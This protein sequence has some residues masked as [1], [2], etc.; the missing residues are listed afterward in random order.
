[1]KISIIA[2]EVSKFGELYDLSIFDLSSSIVKRLLSSTELEE[3]DIEAVFVANMAAGSFS[4]Q[5]HLNAIVSNCFSHHP[6]AFR[7]EAACASGGLA[8][9]AAQ[10][11]LLSGQ[12]QTVM[13]LGVE[14]MT[15]VDA[16]LAN[17]ILCSAAHSESE[18]G[19]TFAGL[20]A[21]VAAAYLKEYQYSREV[22]SA[23]AIKNHA[24]AMANPMAQFHKEL[25]IDMVNSSADVA[26]PLKLFDCSPIS[27]G[28]AA[29]I[30]SSKSH[31][32]GVEIT[33]FGHA[34]DHL[35]L[36]TRLSLTS[37]KASRVAAKQALETS[38]L[39]LSDL[40]AVE[41]HDCFTIA[42]LLAA[43]DLGLS[44]PGKAGS[45]LLEQAGI[46]AHPDKV[47]GSGGLKAGGHPVG[48]TGIKQVAYLASQIKAG[49][50]QTA[51][52]HNVGG[53]GATAVVHILKG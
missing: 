43:E 36:A 8:L 26:T 28:A 4:N 51:L 39:K 41:L 15:D 40:E 53:V 49:R 21:L 16:N 42:E 7:I 31:R 29:V 38:G 11:A 20:Y 45:L 33:G 3:S 47:N 19:M 24:N 9:I 37:F 48:A 17:Q 6:P 25:T 34:Q 30:L 23:V 52:A 5:R 35:S 13:V 12:Y 2:S 32:N 50:Y 22:L 1:M 44:P 27:D 14:K 46:Y 10:L 18:R